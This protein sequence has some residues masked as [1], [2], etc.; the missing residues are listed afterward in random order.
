MMMHEPGTAFHAG[1]R[2]GRA[3]PRRHRDRED[4]PLPNELQ[5]SSPISTYRCIVRPRTVLDL[6]VVAEMGPYESVVRPGQMVATRSTGHFKG[7]A[8]T[9]TLEGHFAS[10]AVLPGKWVATRRK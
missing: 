10:G 2:V 3:V 5:Q 6:S 4:Q 9:G 7:D 1:G 8:V